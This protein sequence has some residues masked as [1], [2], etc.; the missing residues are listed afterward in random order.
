MIPSG[1]VRS[2][3]DSPP[4]A[5]SV[6]HKMAPYVTVLL[7]AVAFHCLLRGRA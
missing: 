2:V 3:V 1:G 5:V 4:A 6:L 7:T